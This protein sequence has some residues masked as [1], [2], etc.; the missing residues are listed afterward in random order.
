MKAIAPPAVFNGKDLD[1]AC[2]V[3]YNF[4]LRNPNLVYVLHV[5]ADVFR[6]RNNAKKLED[7]TSPR[8]IYSV[9]KLAEAKKAKQCGKVIVALPE[10]N[11]GELDEK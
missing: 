4:R 6:A 11:I 10:C 9:S 8:L 7:L 3:S 2:E 5:T 1:R